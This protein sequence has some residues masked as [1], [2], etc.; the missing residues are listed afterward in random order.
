MHGQVI[1]HYEVLDTIGRGAMGV[2]YKARDQR[3]NRVVALK[4]LP[5]RGGDGVSDKVQFKIEARAAASLDHPN[6]CRIYDISEA[7]GL[8]Y[9]AMAFA[10]GKL[11]TERIQRGHLTIPDAISIA[12]QLAQALA[13]A[14][15]RGV[16]HFDLK[17]DN[18]VIELDGTPTLLDFGLATLAGHHA[19]FAGQMTGTPAYMAPEQMTLAE[20][21][22]RADL[23]ALGVIMYEMLTGERPFP[24]D[25]ADALF[26]GVQNLEAPP[27]VAL[28]P[29]VPSGV[30]GVVERL[31]QKDPNQ[32]YQSA[33]QVVDV[34]KPLFA[35]S[36]HN[37][38]NVVTPAE[39]PAPTRRSLGAWP[40]A[41]SG[42]VV[43]LT[44]FSLIAFR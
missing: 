20:C 25:N 1:A 31:L 9:I 29:N 38:F 16:T 35:E 44:I 4:C 39:A 2:V 5:S 6:I 3:L 13:S 28:R 21:D 12:M 32:R 8:T 36:T 14:H 24:G 33:Q 27:L 26:Y 41:I 23:W 40:W 10:K 30:V 42:A 19:V 37:P 15:E 7:D 11:L 34:L 18:V 43:L 17:P 22:H